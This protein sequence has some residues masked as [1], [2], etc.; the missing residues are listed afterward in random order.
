MAVGGEL[1]ALGRHHL[2][3][4]YM[5][6][7]VSPRRRL[8]G[9]EG[10]QPRDKLPLSAMC[11]MVRVCLTALL[12]PRLVSAAKGGRVPACSCS[13]GREALQRNRPPGRLAAGLHTPCR[14]VSP[15]DTPGLDLYLG[16]PICVRDSA[17]L[18]HA[19]FYDEGLTN[20]ESSVLAILRG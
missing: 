16:R 15:G 3:A 12:S 19:D 6:S 2:R 13:I 1:G 7:R 14:G 17:S 9:R 8:R 18:P 20:G 5:G 10:W 4:G 11:G